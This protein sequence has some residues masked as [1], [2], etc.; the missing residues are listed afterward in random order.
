[1]IQLV[2]TLASLIQ[3]LQ[4]FKIW[5]VGDLRGRVP[6]K[7]ASSITPRLF[8]EVQ[9]HLPFIVR[10]FHKTLEELANQS[11]DTSDSFVWLA[12]QIGD[13]AKMTSLE[14]ELEETRLAPVIHQLKF[15]YFFEKFHDIDAYAV[16]QVPPGMR[17][18]LQL[19]PFFACGGLTFEMQVP[20][21]WMSGG[22]K[23]SKSVVHAD[24][25]HNQHCVLHGEKR[26]MLIPPHIPVETPDYGWLD[27]QNEDGTMKKGYETAYGDYAAEIDYN[28]MDLERFPKWKDVPWLLAELKAGDCLYMPV[29]WYH[30]VE[31]GEGPSVT[32][33]QWFRTP[34]EWQLQSDC[35]ENPDNPPGKVLRTDQC[36]FSDDQQVDR[37][38]HKISFT[39]NRTS[40]CKH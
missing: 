32:W 12:E 33:H 3:V 8:F 25:Y 18:H 9:Q 24:S 11:S 27:T 6:E 1:M 21:M 38:L 35:Q 29:S 28:N 14:G 2:I 17:Q 19:L 40:Q 36:S 5:E 4:S 23:P 26:F 10:G 34:A 13:N 37:P 16:S 20:M 39:E 15:K 7:N 31:S 30:Y 22:A